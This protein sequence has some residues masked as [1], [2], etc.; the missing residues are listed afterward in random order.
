MNSCKQEVGREKL[1]VGSREPEA[2]SCEL[3]SFYGSLSREKE[4]SGKG[5]IGEPGVQIWEPGV[6]NHKPQV[7]SCKPRVGSCELRV[8]R[9]EIR[10]VNFGKGTFSNSYFFLEPIFQMLWIKLVACKLGF[11]ALFSRSGTPDSGLP[12]PDFRFRTSLFQPK[13]L[14]DFSGSNLFVILALVLLFSLSAIGQQHFADTVY[15]SS[16]DLIE[17]ALSDAPDMELANI[18]YSIASLEYDRFET[19]LKP[20]L[21]LNAQ[22]PALNRSIDAIPLDDGTESFLNRSYMR[23]NISASLNYQLASTGGQIRI[24]SDLERLDQFAT[25]FND[26]RKS[27]T[28]VPIN[29][30]FE[31]PLF[32]FNALK[33]QKEILERQED[34]TD[35][36]R[37][38]QQESVIYRVINQF[39]DLELSRRRLEMTRSRIN[40]SKDLLNI[41]QKLFE[42]GSGSL[43]NMKQLALDTLQSGIEY[44]S[45]LLEYQNM[46]RSL[47]DLAGLDRAIYLMPVSP[48]EIELPPINIASAIEQAISNRART[49]DIRL[50][51]AQAER[52]IEEA[53][54]DRGV[55]LDITAQLG[56]NNSA[57]EFSGLRNGFQDRELLSVG[58]QMPIT[59][60]G[61]RDINRQLADQQ[62]QQLQ[63]NLE[64]E[65][66]ELSRQVIELYSQYRYLKEKIDVDRAAM[67]T[68]EE[69]Y[70]LVRDQYLRGQTDW[71]TLNQNRSTLDNATLTYFQTRATAV[72]LYYQVRSITLYDFEMDQPLILEE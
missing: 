28:F 19:F 60:W 11:S 61:R 33:W 14:P 35:A 24:F 30:Q 58:L 54:K 71:N 31:Q 22:L 68:A 65:E 8:S 46:S 43:A 72:K 37:I 67:N 6:R 42:R 56:A 36:Q 12:I 41:K 9:R 55:S 53:E 15:L 51:M 70:E 45:L 57:E 34:R 32:Q 20:T 49:A 59:D 29:I 26:Y 17:I 64:A 39:Y 62:L 16:D 27:Y 18:Q 4:E 47:S 23:N 63:L 13:K 7:V 2:V 44:R 52:D 50:R 66:R 25:D 1:E 21:Y 10:D 40:D 69:I 48:D 38:L 5:R 3:Q